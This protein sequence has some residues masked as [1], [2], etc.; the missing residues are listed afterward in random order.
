MHWQIVVF[1]T[2]PCSNALTNSGLY[3]RSFFVSSGLNTEITELFFILLCIYTSTH[4]EAYIN[5]GL[6]V[7]G[8]IVYILVV[9]CNMCLII[10]N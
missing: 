4:K 5:Q 10:C 2:G 7:H 6:K 1:I 3:N 9:L 8:Y